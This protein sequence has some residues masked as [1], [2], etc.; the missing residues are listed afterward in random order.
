MKHPIDNIQ[1]IDVEKLRANDYNPNVVITPEFKLL[2]TSLLK[3]GWIQPILVCPRGDGYEIIDG[4]HRST[5]AKADAD[6]RALTDGKVPC[7]VMDLSEPERMMLTVRINRAKGS[8]QAVKMHELVSK[9]L[10]EHGCSVKQVCE[11]IGATKAE[12]DLLATESVFKKLDIEA[13]AYSR[14]WEPR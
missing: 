14:A 3:S 10:K 4:F 5:L 13:H 7:A 9:L 6:V 12:V 1:W 11:G 8:H 2:K